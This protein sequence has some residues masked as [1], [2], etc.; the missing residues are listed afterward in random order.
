M[1]WG[2][3]LN[4][5]LGSTQLPL[6]RSNSTHYFHKILLKWK[7]SHVFVIENVPKSKLSL[8]FSYTILIF[9]V[10]FILIQATQAG[11]WLIFC[12]PFVHR[13][14][15]CGNE[16]NNGYDKHLRSQLT[17]GQSQNVCPTNKRF[18]F[19]I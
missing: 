6:L 19:Y 5:A 13:L 9:I 7:Y 4:F 3:S 18:F 11:C 17:L 2:Q 16:N 1:K 8:G 14:L 10:I 12:Q 15:C